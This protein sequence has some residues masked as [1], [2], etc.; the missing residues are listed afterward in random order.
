MDEQEFNRAADATL[1]RIEQTLEASGADID[2]ELREGG[3]LELELG[4]GTKIIV[5]RHGAAREIWLAAKSGGFHFKPADAGRWVATRDG[6]ELL[7]ALAR[8]IAEQGGGQLV[9]G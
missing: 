8:C 5:N 3:V 7:A 4:N 2:V 9:L 1:A 6:E